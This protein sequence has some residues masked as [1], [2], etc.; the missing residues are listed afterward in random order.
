MSAPLP[1]PNDETQQPAGTGEQ[2]VAETQTTG[3]VCCN[4]RSGA[5]RPLSSRV[6]MTAN[7]WPRMALPIPRWTKCGRAPVV[8]AV[9]PNREAP[10]P[11]VRPIIR[12]ST[13]QEIELPAV[14]LDFSLDG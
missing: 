6:I 4:G 13:R 1:D 9:V 2:W 5:V 8:S 3:P 12:N 11:E 7:R 14:G 10:R